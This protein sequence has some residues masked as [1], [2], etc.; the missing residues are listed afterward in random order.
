M[1]FPHPERVGET[2]FCPWHGKVQTPQIRIHFSGTTIRHDQPLYV[3]YI[4]PKI[5]K[6]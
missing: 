6:R 1:T 5:A 2:L 4:G 3:V